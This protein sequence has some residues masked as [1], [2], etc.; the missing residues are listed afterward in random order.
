MTTDDCTVSLSSMVTRR[1]SCQTKVCTLFVSFRVHDSRVTIVLTGGVE[2]GTIVGTDFHSSLPIPHR[3]PPVDC[4]E[5]Q[6]AACLV[7]ATTVRARPAGGNDACAHGSD[8]SGRESH[9]PWQSSSTTP[10]GAR[11]SLWRRDWNSAAREC[12]SSS[13]DQ[14]QN[15]TADIDGDGCY[16]PAPT[17]LPT[18]FPKAQLSRLLRPREQ[19]N[20]RHWTCFLGQSIREA[21]ARRWTFEV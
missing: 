9:W 20:P 1:A 6:R 12:S 7:R 14:F 4:G 16:N 3:P 10:Q 18:V 13:S 17:V 5:G 21:K 15:S 19:L 8:T 11:R 2:T